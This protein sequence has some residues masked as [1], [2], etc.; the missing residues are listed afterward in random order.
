MRQKGA[1]K[2]IR[3]GDEIRRSLVLAGLNILLTWALTLT[4]LTGNLT[5]TLASDI[6]FYLWFPGVSALLGHVLGS[7]FL[8]LYYQ[9][10]HPW[11]ELFVWQR[12]EQIKEG[13]TE[14]VPRW[15][16]VS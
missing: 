3:R 4:A 11:R 12:K 1:Q 15:E 8:Y 14:E 13:V 2:Q 7:Y 9:T 10:S 16:M 5:S 6:E